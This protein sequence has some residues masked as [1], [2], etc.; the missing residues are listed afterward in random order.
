MGPYHLPL[1]PQPILP[2]QCQKSPWEC[3]KPLGWPS[4]VELHL[5]NTEKVTGKSG[6]SPV[7]GIFAWDS[8][9]GN[10]SAAFPRDSFFRASHNTGAAP[11]RGCHLEGELPDC[12]EH[13]PGQKGEGG[14]RECKPRCI[15]VHLSAATEAQCGGMSP[16]PSAPRA[17][18]S[19]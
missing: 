10:V 4:C 17:G 13:E 18:V 11:W 5:E 1:R 19:D 9:R 14:I 16:Q 6:T 2:G 15:S 8:D 12:S 3:W 7:G